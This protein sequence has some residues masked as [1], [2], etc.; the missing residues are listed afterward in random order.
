MHRYGTKYMNYIMEAALDEVIRSKV[1]LW[2]CIIAGII[3]SALLCLLTY[4]VVK[5][6]F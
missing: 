3:N 2:T 4:G 5:W 6:Y 1:L